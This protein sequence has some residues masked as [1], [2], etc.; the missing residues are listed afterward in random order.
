MALGIAR[1]AAI[2]SS[3]TAAVATASVTVGLNNLS[4]WLVQPRYYANLTP[5][6]ADTTPIVGGSR[7]YMNAVSLVPPADAFD[8]TGVVNQVK[9][10][11][12]TINFQ[13]GSTWGTGLPAS[14]T[15]LLNTYVKIDNG[16][17]SSFYSLGIDWDVTQYGFRL[18]GIG[19][20][21][22][23]TAAQLSPYRGRWLALV[24][25]ASDNPA[26]DFAAW[27]GTGLNT[28]GWG[29]RTLLVDVAAGTVIGSQ[30][31]Y[32]YSAAYTPDLTVAYNATGGA[33][34]NFIG[35]FV[36]Q[37]T[38]GNTYDLGDVYL[39]AQWFAIGQTMDP[40]VYW[41]SL[42]GSGVGGTVNGIQALTFNQPTDVG[43]Q[44]VPSQW[45]TV[46]GSL[47]S[48]QPNSNILNATPVQVPPL[49]G[50]FVS[51]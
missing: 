18:G 25:A 35:Q 40:A 30:D 6:L 47:D 15:A 39:G 12:Q 19:D 38:D 49:P 27:S 9:R 1:T 50:T 42:V 16:A 46:C 22:K 41:P 44:P 34:V 32:G 7:Q 20:A 10:W 45:Q 36:N 51:F 33:G 2:A 14:Q 43:T 26:S 4:P 5:S 24:G 29:A 3:V 28:Y 37:P 11:V 31:G 23:L 17:V 48:R 21:L 8:M 13:V